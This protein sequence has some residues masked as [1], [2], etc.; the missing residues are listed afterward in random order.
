MQINTVNHRSSH[1]A[2]NSGYDRLVDYIKSNQISSK[3]TVLPYKIAKK[4]AKFHNQDYGIYDSQSVYKDLELFKT[5]MRSSSEKNITHYLHAE[6]DINYAV[7]YFSKRKDFKFV[8]TFHKP[9]EILKKQIKN[10][11]CL[12]KLDGAIAVGVNQV[13]F[14]KE[15]L[16]I[17]NIEYIPHGV[18]TRFF[19]PFLEEK[20]G[21]EIIFVGQHLRDFETLNICIPRIA[22]HINDLKVNVVIRKDF[23]HLIAHHKSIQI[24]NGISDV[25]LKNLYL[26]SKFL[27]LPVFN[28]TA[29]NSILEAMASG[30]AIITNNVGGIPEY[31]NGTKNR[32]ISQGDISGFV[33][34]SITL[35]TNKTRYLELGESSFFKSKAYDWTRI[36][37]KINSFYNSISQ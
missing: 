21:S 15:W 5:L 26:K 30:L 31:L 1:H 29:C 12:K 8:G 22:K 33:E 19:T 28:A 13:E 37:K 18:D 17:D 23:N 2:K 35:L 20:Q 24:H 14:L 36:S 34:D 11:S 6:R 32:L 3:Q 10:P 7:K 4:I 16:G 9:P 27:L 25:A